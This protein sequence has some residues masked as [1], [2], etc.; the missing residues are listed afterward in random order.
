MGRYFLYHICPLSIA[1][2]ANSFFRNEPIIFPTP[3]SKDLVDNLMEFGGFS[4]NFVKQDKRFH[5]RWQNMRF[6]Q[7][8]RKDIM[9]LAKIQE[10][11]SSKY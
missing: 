10:L 11:P 1:E 5:I 6:Q 3:A 9:G 4:E 2:V 7:L 8:I